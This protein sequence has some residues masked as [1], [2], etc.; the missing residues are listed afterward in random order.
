[1]KKLSLLNHLVWTF[2][3]GRS[4]LVMPLALMVIFNIPSCNSEWAEIAEKAKVIAG[5]TSPDAA[6]AIA[7]FSLVGF[8]AENGG[9]I[10]GAKGKVVTPVSLDEF[11]AYAESTEEL[12]IKVNQTL[13]AGTPGASVKVNSNKTIIGV[14]SAGFL[15]GV[16]LIISS[17]S[18]IIIRNLKFTMSTVTNTYINSE[19]REQVAVNDG[20]CITIQGSS[21]NIWIDH[22]EFFNIDAKV[23]TNQDLYDGLID[24]K[25]QSEYLTISWNYFHDHHKCHLIGSSDSDDYDRKITFHHNYY[26][27]IKERLPSYRFGTAHIYNNYFNNISSSAINS[28]MEACL[29]VEKNVFEDTKDPILS[30]SSRLTG[31]WQ[32]IDNDYVNGTGS[33]LTESTC[34]FTPPYTYTANAKS[35]VKSLV[36]KWAGTGKIKTGN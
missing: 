36:T 16:G 28:R 20:D 24:V 11:T 8:A 15:E 14:G 18:N 6:A 10:G 9:T 17:K 2:C 19:G 13:S 3:K 26:E 12:I 31:S 27:N 4:G 29:L 32:L 35:V 33:Q 34:S 30:K 1:M 25:G 23:Q 22:C 7:N 5:G 21:K